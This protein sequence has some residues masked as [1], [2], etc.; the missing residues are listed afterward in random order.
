MQ[1]LGSIADSAGT[2]IGVDSHRSA[3]AG[4]GSSLS[5]PPLPRYRLTG[6]ETMRALKIVTVTLSLACL[7]LGFGLVTLRAID[8]EQMFNDEIHAAR[9]ASGAYPAAACR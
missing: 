2:E 4:R 8:K 3:G 7:A 6:R 9:C 5:I 1:R